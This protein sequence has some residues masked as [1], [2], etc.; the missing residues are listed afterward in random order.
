MKKITDSDLRI[1]AYFLEKKLRE[2]IGKPIERSLRNSCLDI[3][4]LCLDIYERAKKE[5]VKNKAQNES[6]SF[7]LTIKE[8]SSPFAKEKE[9]VLFP[10][11]KEEVDVLN[12]LIDEGFRDI[13]NNCSVGKSKCFLKVRSSQGSGYKAIKVDGNTYIQFMR[14]IGNYGSQNRPELEQSAQGSSLTLSL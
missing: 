2:P 1:L 14:I 5:I 10:L 3:R 9:K 8:F 7:P 12:E 13:I 6:I 4:N 11:T